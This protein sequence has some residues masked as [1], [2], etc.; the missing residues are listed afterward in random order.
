METLSY[1]SVE[2]EQL[3]THSLYTEQDKEKYESAMKCLCFE[4][5]KCLMAMELQKHPLPVV[6]DLNFITT[7][8]ANEKFSNLYNYS[9]NQKEMVHPYPISKW[10]QPVIVED[11]TVYKRI[12]RI[13]LVLGLLSL[14]VS[15]VTLLLSEYFKSNCDNGMCTSALLMIVSSVFMGLL[16]VCGSI[17]VWS[18]RFI[19]NK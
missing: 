17:R 12:Q 7:Y 1:H 2:I 15:Y 8:D 6:E 10:F 5:P 3:D 14:S 16:L 9:D 13:S 11:N 19:Q 18:V 4:C